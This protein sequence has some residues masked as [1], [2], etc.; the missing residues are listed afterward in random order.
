M[1]RGLLLIALLVWLL[2][3]ATWGAL[4]WWIVPRI[5]E[6][7]PQLEARA[8]QALG[9][10]VRL[11]AITAQSGG[12]M[13]S[14]A[15][16]DVQMLDAQGRV[17]LSLP[18]VLVTLSPRSVW[19]LGFEQLYIDHPKLDINRD[20]AG[21]ITVAGLAFSGEGGTNQDTLNWIF[22]QPEL[23][24]Q[25]G[26]VR[27]TDEMRHTAPVVLQQVD[28][29]ARNH[30]RHHDLRADAT[31]PETWGDRFSVQGQ[32]MQPLLSRQ[33]GQW[34]DWEG[35]LYA[36]FARVDLSELR[37]FANL[38]FDLRQGRGALRA[39]GDVSQGQLTGV[40][41]DLALAEVAVTLGR[42]LQ[43]LTLRQIKGR[44]A[45][46][47]LAN[48]FEVSTQALTFDTAEGLHWQG[49]NVRVVS[50]GAEGRSSRWGR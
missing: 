5:G 29:V 4:H 47:L 12:L 46:R 8:S 41:A 48:G 44:V 34:Q 21:R 28:V 23:V 40:T 31:P 38:G 32:F 26:T 3:G 27:W 16:T 25:G 6:F 18:R 30:G 35:Q 19:R 20:A 33:Q 50:M 13:P 17:A 45:G 42:D 10:A 15:L 1:T 11:G 7:R 2:F 24:I 39:W 14:L 37:R 43:P 36:D 49:G 22:S 9:V